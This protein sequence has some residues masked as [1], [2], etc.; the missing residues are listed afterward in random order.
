MITF[1]CFAPP[2]LEQLVRNRDD[3]RAEVFSQGLGLGITAQR[4]RYAVAEQ[5]LHDE[6]QG[7]QVG[8]GEAIDGQIA[9]LRLE[10]AQS[11]LGEVGFEPALSLGCPRP[12]PH[13]GVSAF[14]A[15]AGSA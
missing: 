13:V 1:P 14:V 4:G 3:L 11:I 7:H 6:V 5:A 9:G 2:A 15:G 12:D 8:Q 10:I